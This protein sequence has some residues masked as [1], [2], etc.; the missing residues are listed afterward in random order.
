MRRDENTAISVKIET[1]TT[2]MEIRCAGNIISPLCRSCQLFEKRYYH[3][4]VLHD[5]YWP[6]TEEDNC[7]Y[8]IEKTDDNE[9]N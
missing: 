7:E 3:E 1:V 8:Y 2:E 4:A 5:P 6:M 9:T